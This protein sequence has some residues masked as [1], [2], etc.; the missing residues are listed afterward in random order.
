MSYVFDSSR[1]CANFGAPSGGRS[2]LGNDSLEISETCFAEGDG[3]NVIQFLSRKRA[4]CE[5]S[6]EHPR[7]CTQGN[8]V[9]RAKG[10]SSPKFRMFRKSR[11]RSTP[12]V[13]DVFLGGWQ[14]EYR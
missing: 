4:T 3:P 9:S 8:H 1:M 2:I 14:A 13:S 10:G 7:R 12:V 5:G 6:N 11:R